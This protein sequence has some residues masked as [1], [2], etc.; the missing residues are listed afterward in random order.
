MQF[1]H[2]EI[3]VRTILGLISHDLHAVSLKHLLQLGR[4]IQ[5]KLQAPLETAYK[6]LTQP[7]HNVVLTQ[8]RQFSIWVW[9]RSH[10]NVPGLRTYTLLM[11]CVQ[12]VSEVQSPQFSIKSEHLS[13]LL[14]ESKVYP[15]K[16]AIQVVQDEQ[17]EQA[18]II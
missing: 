5:Q 12:T 15:E 10:C 8:V 17:V 16:H 6:S 3:F 7:V 9:Q 11:H 18:R 13:Q 14:L 4:G 1:W 2:L